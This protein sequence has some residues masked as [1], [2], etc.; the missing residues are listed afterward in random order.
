MKKGEK[1]KKYWVSE[2]DGLC[3]IIIVES[4]ETVPKNM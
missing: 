3:D 4:F 2:Y 1:L